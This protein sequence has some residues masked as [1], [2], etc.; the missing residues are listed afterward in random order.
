MDPNENDFITD[1]YQI[2]WIINLVTL[3]IIVNLDVYVVIC[4]LK[5]RMDKASMVIVAT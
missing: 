2:S 5:F 3:A 1:F 4:R